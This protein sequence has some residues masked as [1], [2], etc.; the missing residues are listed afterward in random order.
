M[1]WSTISVIFRR[2]V[3]DQL[4]DDMII[5]ALTEFS[6]SEALGIG[7]SGVARESHALSRPEARQAVAPGRDLE[8]KRLVVLEPRLELLL[9]IFKGSHVRFVQFSWRC[10]SPHYNRMSKSCARW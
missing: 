3:R 9:A 10:P 6:G 4:L 8:T 5:A 7:F 1:R 2:E